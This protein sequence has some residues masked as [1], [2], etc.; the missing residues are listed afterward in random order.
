MSGPRTAI[1]R[2]FVAIAVFAFGV[3]GRSVVRAAE[4]GSDA[5]FDADIDISDAYRGLMSYLNPAERTRL[6][7]EERAW[8][9]ARDRTCGAGSKGPCAVAAVRQRTHLLEARLDKLSAPYFPRV[10]QCV[11]TRIKT[12][13]SRL[14]EAGG[15][16]IPDSGSSVAYANGVYQ[17]D[18]SVIPGVVRSHVGDPVR[19]CVASLPR[20]CPKNDHRGIIYSAQNL[21]TGAR[22]S[23][24]DSEHACRGA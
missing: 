7:D 18:Y 15:Q 19:L 2:A 20:R 4:S 16:A 14:E 13:G 12:I 1:G 8:I 5:Y 9:V 24:P 21:R 11:T 3:D 23:A 6:R 10:G 22:W 17:V